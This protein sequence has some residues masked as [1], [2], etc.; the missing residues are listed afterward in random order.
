MDIK[1]L[2]NRQLISI[3]KEFIENPSKE[4]EQS[5]LEKK[6]KFS[7]TTIIKWVNLL[8]SEDILNVRVIGRTKLLNLNNQSGTVKELKRLSVIL[9][10]SP[11][12]SYKA[13]I[14]LYGS[15]ARGEQYEDSDIDLLILGDIK[16]SD[17]VNLSE[18]LAKSINKKINFQ[19]FS[20]QEWA[21]MRTKDKPF[22]E[23]VEKDRIL[24]E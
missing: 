6:L 19:V 18:N 15:C 14:Y 16:R 10:L 13:E 11:L 1:Q 22:Y 24:I 7:R 2:G 4:L 20:H 23:R 17:F 9:E 3:L 5:K 21:K 12:K 8:I